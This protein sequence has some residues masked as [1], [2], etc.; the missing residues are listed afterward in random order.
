MVVEPFPSLA[1]RSTDLEPVD[2]AFAVRDPGAASL[3]DRV[4]S[5]DRS[6]LRSTTPIIPRTPICRRS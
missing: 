3:K 4:Q 5:G 2:I 1:L 6:S